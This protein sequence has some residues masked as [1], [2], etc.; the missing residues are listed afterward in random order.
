MVQFFLVWLAAGDAASACRST[1]RESSLAGVLQWVQSV[2]SVHQWVHR[3]Q[4]SQTALQVLQSLPAPPLV[5]PPGRVCTRARSTETRGAAAIVQCPAT[6]SG[7][8]FPR[9]ITS[10]TK[11]NYLTQKKSVFLNLEWLH[12]ITSATQNFGFK[13]TPYPPPPFWIFYAF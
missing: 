9:K 13:M 10:A 7:A 8:F 6:S 5:W 12:M 1:L 4:L 3:L 11:K 2:Q